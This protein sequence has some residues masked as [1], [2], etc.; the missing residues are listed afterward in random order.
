MNSRLRLAVMAGAVLAVG[1]IGLVVL[2]PGQA[3]VAGG[4]DAITPVP[5][6][7]IWTPERLVQDWPAPRRSEPPSRASVTQMGLGV[8]SQWDPSEARWEPYEYGDPVGDVGAGFPWLDIRTVSLASG[9][10]TSFGLELVGDITRPVPDPASRWIA[11]GVV[12]D[13]DGDGMPDVRV[14]I[15]NMA[16]DQHRAWRTDLA[17]G[18]TSASAGPPYGYVGQ[19]MANGG[20]GRWGLDT[21]YPGEEGSAG[22]ATL[23]YSLGP[24]ETAFRFY[25]WASLLEGGRIVATDYAPDVGWLEEGDQPELTLVGPVWAFGSDFTRGEESLTL[26]QTLTFTADGRVV[27]DA[28]CHTGAGDVTAAAGTLQVRDLVLA[29]VPCSAD[30]AEFD[31]A[32]TGVLSA[33]EIAYTIDAGVL[34]LRAGE[35]TVQLVANFEG[36]PA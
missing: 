36:P 28:A 30:V 1:A 5:G 32:L 17:S 2:R 10:V 25:A 19:S 34:E 12:L 27:I 26:V 7:L 4:P 29:E 24:D 31:A 33:D 18:Q 13:T 6:S 14:G 3:P 15:D 22:R 16:G 9:G 23:R 21:W 20:T 35:K 11:Y 8:D